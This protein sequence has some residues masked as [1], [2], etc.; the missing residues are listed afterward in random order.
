MKAFSFITVLLFFLMP[1]ASLAQSVEERQ[2]YHL[3]NAIRANDMEKVRQMV[4]EG[5]D[6]NS[7]FNGRNALHVALRTDSREIV[8]FLLEAGADVNAR[9]D[10]GKGL[11]ILHYAVRSFSVPYAYVEILV[12]MGADVNTKSPDEHLIINDAIRR[13]GDK[14]EALKIARLLIKHGA[15]V[16]PDDPDKSLPRMAILHRRTDMLKL[17][18]EHGANPN[19]VDSQSRCA[20]HYAVQNKN[21]MAAKLLLE[22]GADSGVKD[23][24]GK[25]ALDYARQKAKMAFD[26]TSRTTYNEMIKLLSG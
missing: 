12:K 9:R 15:D 18:L 24:N 25:T 6:V 14:E 10:E 20:L 19:C 7:Q 8:E 2:A 23:K 4:G 13:A 11:S 16:N 21:V 26:E 22:H 3:Q 5:V 1:V 17:V